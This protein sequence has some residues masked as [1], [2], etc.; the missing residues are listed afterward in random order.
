MMNGS[1]ELEI[2]DEYI[3]IKNTEILKPI[4]IVI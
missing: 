4:H 1:E 2:T 3:K